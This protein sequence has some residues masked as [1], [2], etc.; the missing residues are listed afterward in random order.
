MAITATSDDTLRAGAA[1][2]ETVAGGDAVLPLRAD[3]RQQHRGRARDR[4]R[5]RARFGGLDILVNNAGVGMF[6]PV[7]DMTVD[8]W[9]R[10]IDTNLT[11][12][13]YCCRAALP[14]LRARGGGWIINISSLS[15][16]R[17]VRRRRRLL[18]LEGRR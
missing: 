18:R 2:L 9:H 15:P 12:V 16:H 17:S 14:H 1:E 6:R 13:F 8:E 10:V 4:H 5:G 7:A 11:G 3:V